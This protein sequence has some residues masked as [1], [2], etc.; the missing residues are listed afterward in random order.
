MTCPGAHLSDSNDVDALSAD[1][2][3]SSS[4]PPLNDRRGVFDP[5]GPEVLSQPKHLD[6]YLRHRPRLTHGEIV[7][8]HPATARF[9]DPFCDVFQTATREGQEQVIVGTC[10]HDDDPPAELRVH[11]DVLFVARDEKCESKMLNVHLRGHALPK[12][13]LGYLI[14]ATEAPDAT[15]DVEGLQV[16]DGR[17]RLIGPLEDP[18][19]GAAIDGQPRVLG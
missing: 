4:R 17:D 9:R 19:A 2:E 12:R 11:H 1:P 7:D 14:E 6:V 5:D 13:S 8:V 3:L 16:R 15:S 10:P 18:A